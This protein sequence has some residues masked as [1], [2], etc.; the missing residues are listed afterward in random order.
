MGW[1]NEWAIYGRE[2][3]GVGNLVFHMVIHFVRR[4][5]LSHGGD[6]NSRLTK[7]RREYRELHVIW[8]RTLSLFGNE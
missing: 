7:I 2:M 8:T 1:T 3:D 6:I 4:R 5:D